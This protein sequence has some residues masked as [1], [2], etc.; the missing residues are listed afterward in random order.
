[1]TPKAPQVD[2]AAISGQLRHVRAVA[3]LSDERLKLL[4]L[5]ML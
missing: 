5:R 3:Q 4:L 1:M 2:F